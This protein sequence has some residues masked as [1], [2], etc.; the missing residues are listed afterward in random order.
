MK[1][2]VPNDQVS[3]FLNLSEPGA[4]ETLAYGMK[5]TWRPQTVNLSDVA[6]PKK[7]MEALKN[8]TGQDG[9]PYSFVGDMWVPGKMDDL[10]EN[11]KHSFHNL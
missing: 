2:L 11:C 3:V 4:N 5:E 10:K 1:A 6:D 9:G 8:M 7:C